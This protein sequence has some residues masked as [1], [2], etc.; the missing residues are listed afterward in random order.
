MI[1]VTLCFT[2]LLAF[3]TA[4]S[5]PV[6]FTAPCQNERDAVDAAGAAVVQAALDLA[7]AV[8]DVELADSDYEFCEFTTPG[9]CVAEE[10]ILL[11][12]D[13]SLV[14]VRQASMMQA[15]VC[16]THRKT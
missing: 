7:N 8:A 12:A 4:N 5:A 6:P 14:D 3:T 16:K 13:A 11:A 1:R 15:M 9:Q 2:V 10:V